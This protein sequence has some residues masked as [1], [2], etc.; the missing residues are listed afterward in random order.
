MSKDGATDALLVHYALQANRDLV[1]SLELAALR[2]L[3]GASIPFGIRPLNAWYLRGQRYLRFVLGVMNMVNYD[4][5]GMCTALVRLILL[6]G[7]DEL[8]VI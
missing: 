7:I 6:K 4:L 8:I 1:M 3:G 2:L 5:I